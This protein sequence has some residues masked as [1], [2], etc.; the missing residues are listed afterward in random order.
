MR[1]PTPEV[2]RGRR[3]FFFA[4]GEHPTTSAEIAKMAMDN[5]E[6]HSRTPPKFWI[7]WATSFQLVP[8]IRARSPR[9]PLGHS[10]I[11]GVFK[12]ADRAGVGRGRNPRACMGTPGHGDSGCRGWTRAR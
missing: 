11:G 4:C 10:E 7:L 12:R 1:P 2:D 6:Y 5:Q 3:A 8:E 9:A